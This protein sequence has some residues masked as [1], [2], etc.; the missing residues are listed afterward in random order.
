[1]FRRFLEFLKESPFIEGMGKILDFRGIIGRNSLPAIS[2]AEAL[3]AG[4][5]K[6]MGDYNHSIIII[7][8]K[9]RDGKKNKQR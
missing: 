1:M 6:V 3:A 7:E 5:K 4:W 2:D 9:T 8:E